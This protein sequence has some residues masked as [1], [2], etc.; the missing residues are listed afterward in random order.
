[1]LFN[2]LTPINNRLRCSDKASFAREATLVVF[3]FGTRA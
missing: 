2:P 3:L 1:M